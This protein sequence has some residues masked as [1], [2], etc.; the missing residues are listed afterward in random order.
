MSYKVKIDIFEGP[1]DL[2]VYLIENAEMSIYDIKISEITDQYLF[3]I[4]NM[5]GMKIEVAGEFMVLAATLI[6]IKSKMLLPRYNADELSELFHQDPR[7]ELVEKILEYKKFKAAALLLE[8]SEEIAMLICTK[9]QEDL[10][11]FSI[12]PE[13]FVDIDLNQFIN[14]FRLFLLKKK[15]VEE[16][17][18]KYGEIKRDRISIEEKIS[19]IN[20]LLNKNNKITFEELIDDFEDKQ[21]VIATFLALLEL[22]RL[23]SILVKQNVNFGEIYIGRENV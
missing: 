5:K 2:L 14:A 23:K 11:D 6:E 7:T 21:E 8:K 20:K 16:I 17:H 1:F 12:D 15:K 10:S 13:V 19:H 18:K 9:P 3:Y 4:D 22:L